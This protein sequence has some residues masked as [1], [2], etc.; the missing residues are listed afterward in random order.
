[1][2]KDREEQVAAHDRV[3][4]ELRDELTQ[5]RIE[6][7]K[8]RGE[9]GEMAENVA[10]RERQAARAQEDAAKIREDMEDLNRQLMELSRPKDEGCKNINQQLTEIEHLREVIN[11]Q[12]RMLEERRVGLISQ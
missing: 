4:D 5:M 10:T 3:A 6:L 7:N 1:A 12:E 11:E 9:M 2:V 8:L